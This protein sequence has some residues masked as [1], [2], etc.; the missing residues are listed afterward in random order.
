M[1]RRIVDMGSA[2]SMQVSARAVPANTYWE[3]RARR[4]ARDG[5]GLRAVC[6]YGMPG[7]YNGY[8][9]LVQACALRR[10]LRVAPGV[11]VLDVGC[12][13]GRWSR[14]LAASGARVTGTDLVPA[15]VAEAS[16]R[17][18]AEH[19][20]DR[21][22]FLQCDAAELSFEQP[23]DVILCVTVLQHILD[24]DR[25]Q[26]A[27]DRM[28]AHLAP[29]GRIVLLEAAPSWS[30][31]RC[32]TSVFTARDERT[33]HEAFARAGLGCTAI[34]GI[35]PLPLK[36][37]FLPLYGR[38]PRPLALLGLAAITAVS[39]PYDLLFGGRQPQRSWHKLFVLTRT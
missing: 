23:F 26:M 38:L 9:H 18:R 39:L 24:P 16:R 36:T 31:A 35:D 28:S 12:G 15:M 21:C 10:W 34:H 6:S 19:V 37:R 30:D 8:I 11:R 7:F 4:F 1:T 32:N 29:G 14:R 2:D 20:D 17:A 13:V 3:T 33:F 22:E 5:W 25:M 27:L